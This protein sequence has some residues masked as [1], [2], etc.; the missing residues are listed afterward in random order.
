MAGGP[1][2]ASGAKGDATAA[3]GDGRRL[4]SAGGLAHWAA[5]GR[6][7]EGANGAGPGK[8]HALF[9]VHFRRV[10]RAGGACRNVKLDRMRGPYVALYAAALDDDHADF[11]VGIDLGPVP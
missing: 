10:Q 9:D 3:Q 1:N 7:V 4:Q 5:V 6:A 8:L 11:D 2:L